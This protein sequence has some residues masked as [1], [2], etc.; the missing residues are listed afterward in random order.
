MASGRASLGGMP[1]PSFFPGDTRLHGL[2]SYSYVSDDAVHAA[3][4]SGAQVDSRNE[5]GQTPLFLATQCAYCNGIETLLRYGASA[6]IPD[7]KGRRPVHVAAMLPQYA[8]AVVQ[9]LWNGGSEVAVGDHEGYTPLHL[10][11][12]VGNTACVNFLVHCG[13]SVN[14]RSHDGDASLHLAITAGH[15]ESVKAL[16]MCGAHVD[17]RASDGRTAFELAQHSDSKVIKRLIDKFATAQR[18]SLSGGIGAAGPPNSAN[19]FGLHSGYPVSLQPHRGFP[20]QPPGPPPSS[21]SSANWPPSAP[22]YQ[23][24]N[25][26]EVAQYYQQ[27][28]YAPS[29]YPYASSPAQ[30]GS[31]PMPPPQPPPHQYA[32]YRDD[33]HAR[34]AYS[35][36]APVPHGVRPPLLPP[37]SQ[38]QQRQVAASMHYP[39][40]SSSS[41]HYDPSYTAAAIASGAYTQRSMLGD[42]DNEPEHDH[43][44]QNRYPRGYSHVHDGGG[45]SGSSTRTRIADT[46]LPSTGA[47]VGVAD[48]Q[49]IAAGLDDLVHSLQQREAARSTAGGG[50]SAGG[51]SAV[52]GHRGKS[53]GGVAHV[54]AGVLDDLAADASDAAPASRSSK[55]NRQQSQQRSNHSNAQQNGSSSHASNAAGRSAASAPVNSD[56]DDAA[57]VAT[58]GQYVTDGLTDAYHT[59]AYQTDYGEQVH[60]QGRQQSTKSARGGNATHAA[61]SHAS[62]VGAAAQLAAAGGAAD[63]AASDYANAHTPETASTSADGFNSGRHTSTSASAMSTPRDG[64]LAAAAATQHRTHNI[65]GSAP[66]SARDLTA[67]PQGAASNRNFYSPLP[68]ASPVVMGQG[69]LPGEKTATRE[70]S[71][72]TA[73]SP[74]PATVD[75]RQ[76][77]VSASSG[78]AASR[79]PI[80]PQPTTL[81]LQRMTSQSSLLSERSSNGGI[82]S[83]NS[84][85]ASIAGTA[86]GFGVAGAAP[87][88][89]PPAEQSPGFVDRGAGASSVGGYDS[90]RSMPSIH[91]T[92]GAYAGDNT[93]RGRLPIPSQQQQQ[94]QHLVRG[95]PLQNPPN[96]TSS[97][98][99]SGTYVPPNMDPRLAQQQG[100]PAE[101]ALNAAR[102]SAATPLPRPGS[103]RSTSALRNT[104]ATPVQTGDERASFGVSGRAS[105]RSHVV[106]PQ[107]PLIQSQ[108]QQQQPQNQVH[109]A[110]RVQ[111]WAA[112]PPVHAGVVNDGRGDPHSFV[113]PALPVASINRHS[114]EQEEE[115]EDDDGHGKVAGINDHYHQQFAKHQHNPASHAAETGR[116]DHHFIIAGAAPVHAFGAGAAGIGTGPVHMSARTP[117]DKKTPRPVPISLTPR[118][119]ER[120]ILFP[121]VPASAS[122]SAAPSAAADIGSGESASSSSVRASQPVNPQTA[123]KLTFSADT[124]V[125]GAGEASLVDAPV[126]SV[127]ASGAVGGGA[128][129]DPSS[130]ITGPDAAEAL[131]QAPTT[132]WTGHTSSSSVGSAGYVYR[133]GWVPPASSKPV[134]FAAVSA[135]AAAGGTDGVATGIVASGSSAASGSTGTGFKQPSSNSKKRNS[136]NANGTAG[137]S[138]ISGASAGIGPRNPSTTSSSS[139]LAATTQHEHQHHEQQHMSLYTIPGTPGSTTSGIAEAAM[140]A[141]SQYQHRMSEMERQHKQQLESLERQKSSL[142]EESAARIA[143]LEQQLRSSALEHN[144]R[145]A[146]LEA[147]L[148]AATRLCSTLRQQ[149]A[150]S[151]NK[152]GALLLE[153]QMAR[154]ADSYNNST[155]D[156]AP[157]A[158]VQQ[159]A[160]PAASGLI[161]FEGSNIVH[162]DEAK[163]LVTVVPP[164]SAIPAPD[165]ATANHGKSTVGASTDGGT[166]ADSR[167]QSRQATARR[168]SSRTFRSRNGSLT[169]RSVGSSSVSGAESGDDGFEDANGDADGGEQAIPAVTET[170]VSVASSAVQLS[171]EE[172]QQPP[173]TLQA[174]SSPSPPAASAVSKPVSYVYAFE[175]V[176]SPARPSSAASAVASGATTDTN[177]EHGPDDLYA[178]SRD[179][180]HAH[181]TSEPASA[182][183]QMTDRH[184]AIWARFFENA[185]KMTYAQLYPEQQPDIEDALA[186]EAAASTHVQP[187][188]AEAILRRDAAAVEAL[189][190]KGALPTRVA[191][192]DIAKVS[193]GSISA[194]DGVPSSFNIPYP[195]AFTGS[196]SRDAPAADTAADDGGARVRAT[197]LH[198]AAAVTCDLRALAL[199]CEAATSLASASADDGFDLETLDGYGNTPLLAAALAA[200]A[201]LRRMAESD[202]EAAHRF[203]STAMLGTEDAV[204]ASAPADR[205]L[206]ADQAQTSTRT[207]A[208][209]RQATAA[210]ACVR[211]LLESAA[212]TTVVGT[213]GV[214]LAS[215][216]PLLEELSVK[217]DSSVLPDPETGDAAAPAPALTLSQ[218]GAGR[219]SG[220]AGDLVNDSTRRSEEEGQGEEHID[221]ADAAAAS[222]QTSASRHPAAEMIELLRRYL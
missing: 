150:E 4:Y 17:V 12:A 3:I 180:T 121:P 138:S 146:E 89:M 70:S 84:A 115:H 185:A 75:H 105:A 194:D 79:S 55:Q 117:T 123:R 82:G 189:L 57:S 174:P 92:P 58:A 54:H 207:L 133:S 30:Y 203:P 184:L 93:Q 7:Y 163:S 68:S 109:Q 1:T 116:D 41:E 65:G 32:D 176:P 164:P 91:S 2:V 38:Q 177:V 209:Q 167:G 74:Q 161:A 120:A 111:Q 29:L 188:L 200:V 56:D 110:E 172:M 169:A 166:N 182:H 69:L 129:V 118:S 11:A 76:Q 199:L 171:G 86:G 10:A 198:I 23:Q 13:A 124:S 213:D 141:V 143:N 64:R 37:Y 131:A 219:A 108:Q 27:Q 135:P 39:G 66:A 187:P 215:L 81:Q 222:S 113:I 148:Q 114:E 221:T 49:G 5:A 220:M 24:Q 193:D 195:R 50:A 48:M 73:A 71:S 14:A 136:S 42:T 101:R 192:I 140:A 142:V 88:R 95:S 97:S 134:T 6:N 63:M 212:S 127:V 201:L 20:G 80:P 22:G 100:S 36:G 154:P 83:I 19:N 53:G 98:L 218:S 85:R 183:P 106:S 16:L 47:G 60:G 156:S 181:D 45:V 18:T 87:L 147:Q 159:E 96:T 28:G 196:S 211:F 122:A 77:H 151:R 21:S 128:A 61:R 78:A 9:L 126:A 33:L 137:A 158:A 190:L 35:Q 157:P 104:S 214:G 90:A 67:T 15:E 162:I 52:S 205:Q 34:H 40:A 197:P 206:R 160:S 51:R 170:A 173:D 168:S 153:L 44:S 210:I 155:V 59:D 125:L 179:G 130:I 149:L 152:E 217:A 102:K 175:D 165:T 46:A 62:A 25:A 112:E 132:A 216:L 178:A 43:D 204:D 94:Q 99:S 145:V 103:A 72:S 8:D 191:D 107:S 144:S 31:R 208:L 119:P 202:S 26:Y 139:S 186:A